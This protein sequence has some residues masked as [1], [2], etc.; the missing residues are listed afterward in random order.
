MPSK[1]HGCPGEFSPAHIRRVFQY[2]LRFFCSSAFVLWRWTRRTIAPRPSAAESSKQGPKNVAY[3]DKFDIIAGV[4]GAENRSTSWACFLPCRVSFAGRFVFACCTVVFLFR[5]P[6]LLRR[7]AC[8]LSERACVR[9]GP[10]VRCAALP[11]RSGTTQRAFFF[12]ARGIKSTVP[13]EHG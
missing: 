2:S 8:L 10:L 11:Y 5:H 6:D 9:R 3:I 7:S 12:P 4:F 1:H 13:A